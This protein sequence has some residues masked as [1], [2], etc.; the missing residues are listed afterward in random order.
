M[1]AKAKL[2]FKLFMEHYDNIFW[3][4][5]DLTKEDLDLMLGVDPNQEFNK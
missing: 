3:Y 4:S 5:M 2:Y 1:K